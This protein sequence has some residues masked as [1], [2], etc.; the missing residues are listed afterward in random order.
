MP[1]EKIY[2]GYSILR[3]VSAG[4]RFVQDEI[5]PLITIGKTASVEHQVNLLLDDYA[6]RLK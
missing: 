4:V 2:T 1:G 5:A 6:K 3:T